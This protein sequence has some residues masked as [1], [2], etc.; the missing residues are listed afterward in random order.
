MPTAAGTGA[1]NAGTFS[2]VYYEVNNAGERVTLIGRA[3]AEADCRASGRVNHN[4]EDE[5]SYIPSINI[6]GR[7]YL[8]P[9]TFQMNNKQGYWFGLM[10]FYQDGD[11]KIPYD[12]EYS[13]NHYAIIAFPDDPPASGKWT[14][15]INEQNSQP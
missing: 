1:T 3:E 13:K 12:N 4:Y 7:R 14:F 10:K 15:I 8:E 11:K 6:D 5:G 9:S 2:G